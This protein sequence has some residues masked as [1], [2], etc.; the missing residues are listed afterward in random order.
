VTELDGELH[1]LG[2]PTTDEPFTSTY[3]HGVS[4]D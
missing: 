4:A 1:I 2:T 3:L